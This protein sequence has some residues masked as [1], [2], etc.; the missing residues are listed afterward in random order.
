MHLSNDGFKTN[1]IEAYSEFI[2][3]YENWRKKENHTRNKQT[4]YN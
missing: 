4:I 3:M 2:I 1:E